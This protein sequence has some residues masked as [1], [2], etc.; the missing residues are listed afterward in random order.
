[1]KVKN[2]LE[3]KL[4]KNEED[5]F[6][7]R[8]DESYLERRSTILL[9]VRSSISVINV[10]STTPPKRP[11]EPLSM[12]PMIPKKEKKSAVATVAFSTLT[13][14]EQVKNAMI[15]Q[16]TEISLSPMRTSLMEGAEE[17]LFE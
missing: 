9:S 1:M 14:T 17:S 11:S 16:I 15:A 3:W 6:V 8:I 5:F 7:R 10:Q 2:C 4:V 13:I 12:L